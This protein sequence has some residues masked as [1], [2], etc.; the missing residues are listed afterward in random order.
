MVE[1]LYW[2][3]N[4]L[5]S[6]RG[7]WKPMEAYGLLKPSVTPL[8]LEGSAP[9]VAPVAAGYV[10]LAG[11]PEWCSQYWQALLYRSVYWYGYTDQYNLVLS[12]AR[13]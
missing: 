12:E 13:I 4:K 8:I 11:Y 5:Y 7:L 10:R 3:R 2:L 9:Q 1:S 6:Y